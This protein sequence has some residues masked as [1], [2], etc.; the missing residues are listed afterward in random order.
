MKCTGDDECAPRLAGR[1]VA[2][3]STV[4]PREPATR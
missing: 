1:S 2:I 3:R 4:P